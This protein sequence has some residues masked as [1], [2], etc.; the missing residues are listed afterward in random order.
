[1]IIGVLT[2]QIDEPYQG[3]IWKGIEAT[4]SRLGI[5]V[6]CF[7]GR[8]ID[9]PVASEAAAAIVYSLADADNLD[10]L[11]VVSTALATF[12]D[13]ERVVR[14]F[15]SKKGLP[16]VSVGIKVPGV[17]SLTVN[18]S[19]SLAS[20][21]RHLV[22]VH[23]CRDFALIG[24]PIGHPEADERER[25]FRA[26]LKEEDIAFDEALA[27]R[28]D[29][30]R[31][32]GAEAITRLLDA[33]TAF[34]AVFCANDRMA[35]G[36]LE[37]LHR[38]CLRVPE[39]I[40]V[41]GFDGVEE[42]S[43]KTP[44]LTTIIQPLHELGSAAV[45]ML[46]EAIGG[47]ASPDRELSCRP[48][49]RQSC[50]CPPGKSFDPLA[51][52]LPADAGASVAAAVDELAA[53]DPA[54]EADAFLARLNQILS[55]ELREGGELG[56]WNDYLSIVR[57]RMDRRRRGASDSPATEPAFEYARALIGELASRDQAERRIAAENK[58]ATLRSVGASLS[59]GFEM[60][61][62]LGRFKAG[63][64][65][66]GL[67]GA[68]LALFEGQGAPPR[69][70][71]LMM[72]PSEAEGGGLPA[73]GARFP[74]K[75]LLPSRI[76][77]EW[78]NARWVLEPL[79][80]QT[81]LLGYMMLPGGLEETAIYDALAELVSSALK[82]TLLLQQV[83]THERRLEEEVARRTA[84]LTDI[85]R[86]LTREI[87]RRMRLERDVSEISNLTM[88]RIG[89]DL[90]D[91]VCQQLAG[92]AMLSSALKG[93]LD[94]TDP[95]AADA[96]GRIDHLLSDSIAR[97][98]KLARGLYPAGLSERGFV[99]AVKE[100]VE[101]ARG[102]YKIPVE[103]FFDPAF[104]AADGDEALQLYRIIQEALN[105]ALRH[106]GSD[107]IR[108]GLH[109]DGSGE[110]GALTYRVEVSDRGKGMPVASAERGMGL[111]IMRYRAE[112]IGAR[113]LF[114]RLEPGTAVSCRYTIP[115]GARY[116]EN[117]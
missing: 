8:R 64:K 96:V 54:S 67:P 3:A 78:R 84:E 18:G 88:Q 73:G 95:L 6:V 82:G 90:H 11:I 75:E 25:A 52:E 70:A 91:D 97:T 106:S 41:L 117:N 89:Q 42:S 112:T 13:E 29:F 83:R 39:D 102:Y 17:P 7:A 111:R 37:T 81:E 108:V 93:R 12:V 76:D 92:I 23:G 87:G 33:G 63:L 86:E 46:I 110:G 113:L 1:M 24:G 53:Y 51:S 49:I 56:R 30:L 80:F 72:S 74:S 47:R 103:F 40:A 31:D 105:N 55:A 65:E 61:V 109:F 28:G 115:E 48:L 98:K 20:V 94:M 79:V 21:V 71:R 59:G 57:H 104:R 107:H 32:S 9:S 100:L 34:D 26:V 116:A 2:A 62:M 35:F 10:G 43:Y 69:W 5:G 44:P 99:S 22:H 101:A 16:Q 66:L 50:G 27:A 68:Y 85:N 4:A 45:E 38:R 114:E 15:Q 60:P 14:F 36:A 77:P 58:L 19:D